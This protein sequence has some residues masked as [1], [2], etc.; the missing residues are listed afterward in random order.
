MKFYTDS[1]YSVYREYDWVISDKNHRTPEDYPYSFSSHYIW[2]T[3]IL[4][5]LFRYT[6]IE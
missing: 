6:M 2:K 3:K 1:D 5:I 4:R